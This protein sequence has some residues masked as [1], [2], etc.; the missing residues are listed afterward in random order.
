MPAPKVIYVLWSCAADQ[1]DRRIMAP[2]FRDRD[3]AIAALNLCTQAE[4]GG[5][6]WYV[7]E[8]ERQAPPLR[9]PKVNPHAQAVGE[10]DQA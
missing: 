4:T 5:R 8:F 10:G 9:A 1:S 3:R 6:L 7:S 2:I